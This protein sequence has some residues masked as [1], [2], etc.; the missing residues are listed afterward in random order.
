VGDVSWVVPTVQ[1]SAATW[2]PGTAAHSWQAVAAG[3]TTIGY[4]GMMVA[5]K[6]MALTAADLFS[7]PATIAAAKA[8]LDAKRGPAFK[9]ETAL[10]SQPPQLDYRKGSTP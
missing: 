2:V 5:A 8:E 4:K 1:L 6:T 3:G 7:A 9:Y 10:G